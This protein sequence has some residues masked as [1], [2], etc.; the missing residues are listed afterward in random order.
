M[1]G[2]SIPDSDLTSTFD[3]KLRKTSLEN[4]LAD[5]L[6][7][8]AEQEPQV[9]VLEDCHW[10]DPLSRDL[11]DVVARVVASSAVLL[12]LVYRP[13]AALPQGLG[14]AQ[15]PQIEE[16]PL[17][18][19]DEAHM[20]E[21]AWAGSSCSCSTTTKSRLRRTLLTELVVGRAQGNPVLRRGSSWNY[22][23][24]QEIG[25]RPHEQGASARSSSPK[26]C[27]A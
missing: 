14:L 22:V 19:L 3:A 13:E 25:I 23:H 8:R 16:L 4:L 5:Y 12:V 11:L 27:T 21:L 9:L 18:A 17:A 20:T 24:A 26:V 1:F 10:L 2:L 15:L 6:R 7:R